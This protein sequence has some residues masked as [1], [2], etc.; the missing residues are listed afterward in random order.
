MLFVI[1]PKR[2]RVDVRGYNPHIII[3]TACGAWHQQQRVIV[4]CTVFCARYAHFCCNLFCIMVVLCCVFF[5]VA[6]LALD[7]GHYTDVIMGTIASQITSFTIVYSTV[8]S[9]ADQTKY[10]SSAS[11]AFV[12][13]IHRIPVNSPHKR[14]VTRKIF[15]FDDIIMV[16]R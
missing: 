7:N 1:T 14:P 9:D 6:S 2:T 12:W 16:L 5:G 15:P 8:Y 10:Q 4:R 3:N 13:G 11:L